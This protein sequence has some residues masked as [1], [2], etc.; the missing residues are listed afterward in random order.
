MGVVDWLK[1]EFIAGLAG[2]GGR[3]MLSDYYWMVIWR[4]WLIYSIIIG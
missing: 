3:K 4:E 2:G 1:G